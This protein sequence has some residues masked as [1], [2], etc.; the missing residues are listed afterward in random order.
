MYSYSEINLDQ[1]V[2]DCLRL[3]VG[4]FFMTELYNV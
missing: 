4:G 3:E 1:F 2:N